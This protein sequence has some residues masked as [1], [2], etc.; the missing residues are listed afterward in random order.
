MKLILFL[1][2]LFLNFVYA[3][4]TEA[5]GKTIQAILDG[6]ANRVTSF[7]AAE[8][9]DVNFQDSYQNS[10]LHHAVIIGNI[11]MVRLLIAH[12][13][14]LSA[15]DKFGQTALDMARVLNNS[16]VISMLESA[17]QKITPTANAPQD[18]E[19]FLAR[20]SQNAS[21]SAD[22]LKESQT[23]K[24]ALWKAAITQ[25]DSNALV[26]LLSSGGDQYINE[27]FVV[28]EEKNTLLH[29]AI[30]ELYYATMYQ[31]KRHHN[32]TDSYEQKVGNPYK[33]KKIIEV[34]ADFGADLNA[35]FEQFNKE[36]PL[37]L[38]INKELPDIMTLLLEKGADPNLSPTGKALDSPLYET[39]LSKKLSWAVIL[40]DHKANINFQYSGSSILWFLFNNYTQE[41]LPAILFALNHG[42]D[43]NVDGVLE[44]AVRKEDLKMAQLLLDRGA[45]PNLNGVLK[46]AVDQKDLQMIQTLL[47]HGANPDLPYH[48]FSATTILEHARKKSSPE[49]VQLLESAP[50]GCRGKLRGL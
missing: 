34:L 28:G 16:Q 38:A 31:R 45:D 19:S 7:L 3:D 27:V 2:I 25:P 12:G 40:L 18:V 13:A 6:D 29:R 1:P 32:V 42:A 24:K 43:P 9:V 5:G 30:I 33:Y 20:V 21:D 14:D 47:N 41:K 4:P 17:L 46:S 23:M 22:D 10:L 15:E 11:D 39:F 44:S 50:A 37:T 48:S 49:V 35:V 26:S 36:T 8:H